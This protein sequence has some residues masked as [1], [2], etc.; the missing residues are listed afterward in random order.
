[1]DKKLWRWA[2]DHTPVFGSQK[3]ADRASDLLRD[4]TN[5][6]YWLTALA[7]PSGETPKEWVV[8]KAKG[9]TVGVVAAILTSETTAL[10]K[11]ETNR[12]RPNG[13]G[14]ESFPSSHTSNAAV[15]ATL[16]SQNLESLRLPDWG[17]T[18]G[19]IGLATLTAG[20]AWARVEARQHFPS[21]VLAGG[22]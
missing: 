12:V 19:R 18:V 15:H 10:L 16:A 2:S 5:A 7:T 4:T 11:A 20:T 17:R 6:A 22:R 8:A 14:D 21:D 9:V 3:R 1:M 13:S